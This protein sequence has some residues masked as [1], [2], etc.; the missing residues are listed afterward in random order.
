MVQLKSKHTW[1]HSIRLKSLSLLHIQLLRQA[2]SAWNLSTLSIFLSSLSSLNEL[3]GNL[4]PVFHL[5]SFTFFL[6]DKVWFFSTPELAQM[7]V[8]RL[9]PVSGHWSNSMWFQTHKVLSTT[10]LLPPPLWGKSLTYTVLSTAHRGEWWLL[11]VSF[12]LNDLT[13]SVA[14]RAHFQ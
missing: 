10:Q 12:P 1:R 6:A 5:P 9:V 4:W 13:A 8:T 11:K 3:C 2:F 14:L 7:R